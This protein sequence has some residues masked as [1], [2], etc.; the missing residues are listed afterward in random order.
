MDSNKP[1]SLSY[2]VSTITDFLDTPLD[3]RLGT[4]A[5]FSVQPSSD[6]IERWQSFERMQFKVVKGRFISLSA[7]E[8]VPHSWI[9]IYVYL[10]L[11]LILVY[12]EDYYFPSR[13][14]PSLSV[15][16]ADTGRRRGL[17]TGKKKPLYAC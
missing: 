13:R 8:R 15:D 2:H 4:D 6:S 16:W 14:S 5:W 3:V 12:Q 10:R 1:V 9:S 7:N 17:L 11:F